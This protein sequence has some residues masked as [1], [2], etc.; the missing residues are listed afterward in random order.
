MEKLLGG[1]MVKGPAI[2]ERYYKGEETVR[3]DGLIPETFLLY[4]KMDI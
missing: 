2:I 1:W 4:R 3:M